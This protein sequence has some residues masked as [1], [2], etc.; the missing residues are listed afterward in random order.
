MNYKGI[1]T[2]LEFK[3]M[4]YIT[5]LSKDQIIDIINMQDY[6]SITYINGRN[7]AVKKE[8]NKIDIY[9]VVNNHSKALM[10]T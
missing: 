7:Q 1:I 5:G 10:F 9:E 8:V 4:L 2:K 6:F 3:A